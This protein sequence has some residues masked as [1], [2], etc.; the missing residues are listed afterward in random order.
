MLLFQGKWLAQLGGG[1]TEGSSFEEPIP[2]AAEGSSSEEE[3]PSGAGLPLSNLPKAVIDEVVKRDLG[4][5]RQCY[6][7][8]LTKNPK[9]A[10][11]I[12]VKFVIGKDGAVS[13]ATTKSSTMKPPGVAEC[14]NETFLG[15]KFPP[16][17][18]GGIT[19]VSYPFDF[20]STLFDKKIKKVAEK[21]WR[22]RGDLFK[23][24]IA[25]AQTWDEFS[26]LDEDSITLDMPT[27]S[28]KGVSH[29]TF[30]DDRGEKESMT[31]GVY[32][33]YALNRDSILSWSLGSWFSLR[34]VPRARPTTPWAT[35]ASIRARS[36]SSITTWT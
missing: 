28:I 12:T 13:S 29:L 8:E 16:P 6:Q 4:S 26:G 20:K 24:G 34:G 27:K 25:Q 17:K 32:K 2:L 31:L 3:D 9:L 19:I 23:G 21:L 22:K 1:R 18:G 7:E 33:R 36:T 15:M 35:T 11:K 10:G 30:S 5:I 14:L